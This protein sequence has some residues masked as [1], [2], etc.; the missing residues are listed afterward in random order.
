MDR[1]RLVKAIMRR[2]TVDKS[3]AGVLNVSSIKVS[4]GVS[5]RSQN[6]KPV[7]LLNS[8]ETIVHEGNKKYG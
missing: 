1:N 3:R 7:H 4:S 6:R 2:E 8:S 5:L